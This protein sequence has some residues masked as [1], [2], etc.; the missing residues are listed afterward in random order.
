MFPGAAGPGGGRFLSAGSLLARRVAEGL[1]FR[2]EG[3]SGFCFRGRAQ[4]QTRNF[5]RAGTRARGASE[6]GEA[7][8]GDGTTT[9]GSSR[10]AAPHGRPAPPPHLPAG[11]AARQPPPE[12][13]P[14]PPAQPCR[15]PLR[16]PPGRTSPPCPAA[17][18]GALPPSAAPSSCGHVGGRW[19]VLRGR[20]RAPPRVPRVRAQLGGVQ[21]PARLHRPHP[22]P[23]RENRHLQDPA[24][25]GTTRLGWGQGVGPGRA[26]GGREGFA[27][28]SE[29]ARGL[30]GR[31]VDMGTW[32]AP[33]PTPEVSCV[34][35]HRP[36]SL[37]QGHR[38]TSIGFDLKSRFCKGRFGAG[39]QPAVHGGV[40]DFTLFLL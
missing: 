10:P 18:L 36:R 38:R 34:A 27:G 29:R 25:Q 7:A 21:R 24:P 11:R 5:R 14:R 23:G 22:W 37:C 31:A 40:Q 6:R 13:A 19:V 16:V 35:F 33:S 39:E 12:D 20:V 30:G 26:Q 2:S 32:G 3:N 4:I 15:P 8:P 9:L 17:A 1:F 28:R